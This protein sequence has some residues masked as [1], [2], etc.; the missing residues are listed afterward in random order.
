MLDRLRSSARSRPRV[1]AIDGPAGSGKSTVAKRLSTLL[2]LPHLDT[3]ATYRAVTLAVLRSG[4]AIDD[5]ESVAQAARG[6]TI[7]VGP[8]T[9]TVDDVDVT[10]AIREPD[11]TSAVS[12]VA[13]NPGVRIVLAEAQ[14]QWARAR[15]AAV[16]EGR[17][18]GTAVFPDATLKV[19]LHASVEERAQRRAAETGDTDVESMAKAIA[20]RDHLDMTRESDPLTV[21]SDAVVVDSTSMSIDD[22]VS[23]IEALWEE[24]G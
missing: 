23:T 18:I 4:V 10:S 21:A 16:L 13:A 8:S 2:R 1:L 5:H 20:T 17:D 3:G 22:V 15:G 12:T 7:V 9:V 19:Y 24:Q 6:A 14:R 11:V